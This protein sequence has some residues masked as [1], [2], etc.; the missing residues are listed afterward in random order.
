MGPQVLTRLQ[1][2]PKMH[3]ESDK[4][5]IYQIWKRGRE[6]INR[7]CR[8][9]PEPTSISL[10]K[11][12]SAALPNLYKTDGETLWHLLFAWELPFRKCLCHVP[13][14]TL[15]LDFRGFTLRF[16]SSCSGNTAHHEPSRSASHQQTPWQKD[17][18]L[19][20]RHLCW[21]KVPWLKRM[22]DHL[23]ATMKWHGSNSISLTQNSGENMEEK[24]RRQ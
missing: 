6:S 2:P 21:C 16:T 1:L 19:H 12:Y 4:A 18:Y 24:N 23:S 5:E 20:T 14:L 8:H 9:H 10:E 13:A 3:N 17:C 22:N 7:S 11:T 15:R